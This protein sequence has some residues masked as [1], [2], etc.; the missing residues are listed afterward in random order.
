SLSAD[1]IGDYEPFES[2]EKADESETQEIT[3][4]IESVDE[5]EIPEDEQPIEE[6]NEV[7]SVSI[8]EEPVQE[9]LSF[10]ETEES[11]IQNDEKEIKDEPESEIPKPQVVK[12]DIDLGELLKNK[13]ISKIIENV[14]DYDMDEFTLTIEK[15]SQCSSEEEALLIIDDIAHGSFLDESSREIK[16]FKKIISDIF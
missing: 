8:I 4:L 5:F 7:E 12:R 15:I 11:D 3:E 16:N 2:A 9:D 10:E 13:K 6:I 1:N 14:F